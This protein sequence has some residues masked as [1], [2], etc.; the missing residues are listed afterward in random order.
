MTRLALRMIIWSIGPSTCWG[1]VTEVPVCLNPGNDA[2]LFYR[3]KM[4]ASGILKQADVNLRWRSDVTACEGGNGIVIAI[5]RSTPA[6][7]HPRALA[8][9]FPFER[10]RIVVFLDRVRGTTGPGNL[11]NLL[12][13]VLAHEIVHTLQGLDRHSAEGLMKPGWDRTDHAVIARGGLNLSGDDVQF[14]RLG[15]SRR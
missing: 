14:V 11:P 12:G 1:A 2:P 7:I 13:H 8:Y 10:N 5:S 4:T 3:S 6:H 9:A 15:L